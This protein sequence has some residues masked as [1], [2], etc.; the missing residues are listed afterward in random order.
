MQQIAQVFARRWFFAPWRLVP[1]RSWELQGAWLSSS[2]ATRSVPSS[3]GPPPGPACAP[4]PRPA[5]TR[6]LP[7]RSARA[8]RRARVDK[9]LR[10]NTEPS[11]NPQIPKSPDPTDPQD[12]HKQLDP[13][14]RAFLC[15]ASSSAFCLASSASRRA[16]SSE[17]PETL[18]GQWPMHAARIHAAQ[19]PNGLRVL[20][21]ICAR[22]LWGFVSGFGF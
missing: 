12:P 8:R 18:R 2:S 11:P 4:S 20:Y 13:Q 15:A 22:G 1:S 17:D 21:Q 6:G 5:R 14:T 7:Q 9:P 10:T 3:C 19:N 16:S